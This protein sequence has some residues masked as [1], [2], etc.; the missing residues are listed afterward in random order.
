MR[1]DEE[2]ATAHKSS[3]RGTHLAI[4]ARELGNTINPTTDP[5]ETLRTVTRGHNFSF[6]V[7]YLLKAPLEN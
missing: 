2:P 5:M 7:L 6:G 4:I 3:A 1:F